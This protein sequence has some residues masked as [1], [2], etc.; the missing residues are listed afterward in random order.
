MN[1]INKLNDAI[2]ES[3]PDHLHGYDNEDVEEGKIKD[4]W[5]R[6]KETYKRNAKKVARKTG[7]AIHKT[8]SDRDTAGSRTYNRAATLAKLAKKSYDTVKSLRT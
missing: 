7:S 1:K 8:L 6:N 2:K 3:Y 4:Y 5:D